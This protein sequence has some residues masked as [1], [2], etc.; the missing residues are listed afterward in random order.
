M[1]TRK[2]GLKK[3][4]KKK[5]KKK[6]KGL[7]S[8]KREEQATFTFMKKKKTLNKPLSYCTHAN[9]DFSLNAFFR[10]IS[11]F[12]SRKQISLNIF[13][14]GKYRPGKKCSGSISSAI[15]KPDRIFLSFRA[16]KSVDQWW[17]SRLK[18]AALRISVSKLWKG[19]S[20]ICLKKGGEGI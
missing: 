3:E 13:L 6:K 20:C 14:A 12:F 19:R 11:S 2:K 10:G 15:T 7:N 9:G 17:F 18:S 4:V 8:L 5:E 1:I 16:K